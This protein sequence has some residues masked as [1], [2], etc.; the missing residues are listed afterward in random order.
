MKG[1]KNQT[2]YLTREI[3]MEYQK[4]AEQLPDNGK[5][6]VGERRKLRIE[7]QEKCGLTEIEAINILNGNH[8]DQYLNKYYRLQNNISVEKDTKKAEDLKRIEVLEEL[9]H[10]K[11][12]LGN[13]YVIMDD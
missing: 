1:V 2:Q 13:D 8:V 3:A 6:D 11:K 7:L 9:E 5:Q 10:L 12:T 4:K